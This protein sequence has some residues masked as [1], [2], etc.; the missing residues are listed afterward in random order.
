MIQEEAERLEKA[1]K[2]VISE[3]DK[4]RAILIEKE[5]LLAKLKKELN[6]Q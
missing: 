2:Q 4:W 6:E 5:N 1:R 3:Q